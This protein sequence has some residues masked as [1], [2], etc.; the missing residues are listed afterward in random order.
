MSDTLSDD[1]QQL[2]TTPPPSPP[3]PPR[4]IVNPKSYMGVLPLELR[5]SPNLCGLVDDT[6]K[7]GT[8]LVVAVMM[9]KMFLKDADVSFRE[10]IE[11]Y[12]VTVVGLAA[13]HLLIKDNLIRLHKL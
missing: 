7:T 8:L 5:L 13:Y 10:L 2:P 4:D 1:S 12:S 11:I 9:Q 6:L 3:S